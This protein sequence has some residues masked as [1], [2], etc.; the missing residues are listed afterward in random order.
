MYLNGDTAYGTFAS[1]GTTRHTA[2]PHTGPTTATTIGRGSGYIDTNGQVVHASAA[3]SVVTAMGTNNID[4]D[5]SMHS[6]YGFHFVVLD[7]TGKVYGAASSIANLNKLG[8]T[9]GNG[10]YDDFIAIKGMRRDICAIRSN[11][12]VYCAGHNAGGSWNSPILLG[13]ASR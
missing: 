11:L 8:A 10:A 9:F 6:E 12:E 5:S 3:L 1:V 4:L 2:N 7:N 13:T